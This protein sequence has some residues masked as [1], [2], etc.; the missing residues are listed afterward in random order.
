MLQSGLLR[1][2]RLRSSRAHRTLSWSCSMSTFSN[3]ECALRALLAFGTLLTA[4][5]FAAPVSAATYYV[6]ADGGDAAQCTGRSDA[7]Y[8][9]S[10][11][12]QACAWKHPFVALPPARTPR[13]AGGDTLI[14]AAGTYMMGI[15]A[16]D[17]GGCSSSYSYDCH[18]PPLPSGP[19]A[20]QPTRILGKGHD[21]G[22]SAPPQ[23]WGT[24]RAFTVFNLRGSSNIEIGCFEVTDRHAC[25]RG[26]GAG[27][28]CPST[29]TWARAG[30]VAQDASNVKLTDLNIHGMADKGIHAGRLRDWTMTRVTLRANGWVG[31]DGDI[32]VGAS[33]NSGNIIFRQS[34]IAWNGCAEKYPT[35]EIHACWAQQA[36]GYGDGLGTH[37]TGGHWLF[38]DTLVH[39]NTSDGIDLLYMADGGSVTFRRVWAEGNAGNQLKT[40][41]NA[42]IENSVIVGNCAFFEGKFSM[43]AGDNCRALGNALSIGLFDTSTADL[44]NNTISSQGDCLVLSSGGGTG[45][46]VNLVNNAMIGEID[47]TNTAERSC[48]HYAHNSSA[49]VSWDKNLVHGVK[50][51]SCPM[52]S[53]CTDPKI[54]RRSYDAFDPAPL[55]GSAL[56]NAA[57]GSR[58]PATDYHNRA[59]S[60]PDVGAVEFGAT[61]STEPAPAPAPTEP[62]MVIVRIGSISAM[63]TRKGQSVLYS[64]SVKVV[65]QNGKVTPHATVSGSW[66][67]AGVASGSGVTDAQGF[68]TID[69]GKAVRGGK[70]TFCVTS[71]TGSGMQFDGVK[72]C[73]SSS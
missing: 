42:R 58:A 36:G 31:W 59:R 52:G 35:T 55:S 2:A 73:A 53:I 5:A 18:M 12:A 14:V 10:G 41:G 57:N 44:V 21:A 60:T 34:E 72:P 49:L 29:G 4:S 63:S 19:S 27:N 69:G 30:L 68:T 25:I 54:T 47:W 70:A 45:A 39:H 66:S 9:G 61:S 28:A 22:C 65:D 56:I 33:S 67:N 24:E 71:V 38:E 50:N 17:T 26:H 16:P 43:L 1:T 20:T 46:R 3:R 6:R 7:P 51:V 8:P 64:A 40:K 37:Q 62:T 13:I 11:T 32:G 23:L 15:G 48:A